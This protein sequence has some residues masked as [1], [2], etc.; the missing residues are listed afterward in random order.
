[1]GEPPAGRGA[2]LRFTGRSD[3]PGG[4][5][6][7]RYAAL[8]LG[9]H[10]GDDPERVAANRRLLAGPDGPPV[11][12]MQQVHG[13]RVTVLDR[14]PGA[15]VPDS[16]ALVTTTPGLPVAVLV[17]DCVPVLLAGRRGEVVAAVHA[18]RAGV[19]AGV[20]AAAVRAIAGLGV[21][22]SALTALIGPAIGGCCYEVPGELR[23]QV[24]AAVPQ[25]R[26]RTRWGTPSLDL[27][28]A[29]TAQLLAAGVPE[30]RRQ[31]PCTFQSPRHYS[32][33]R[34]GVTGRFAGVAQIVP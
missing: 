1:M 29:V 10:V 9:G 11:A 27:P 18:G 14:H 2:R 19:Q 20:A 34:D 25:A 33:R 12:F 21:A 15:E 16:D 22:P 17:A 7:G 31:G 28:A 6:S 26:A 5:S 32:Y 4:V 24:C 30:V 8:N 23:E 3:P 13:N